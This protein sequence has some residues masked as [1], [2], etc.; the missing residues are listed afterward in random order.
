MLV[1]RLLLLLV[2]A[3][4]ATS[5]PAAY[6]ASPEAA[7]SEEAPP[8]PPV[9]NVMP[10]V[11]VGS[12][13]SELMLG[14]LLSVV[15][16]PITGCLGILVVPPFIHR[17]HGRHGAAVTSFVLRLG[18]PFVGAF[19]AMWLSPDCRARDG[20]SCLF[21]GLLGAGAGELS[22]MVIDYT[23][24]AAADDEPVPIFRA[25][26]S[27]HSVLAGVGVSHGG[28]TFSVAGAF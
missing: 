16:C 19:G 23:V 8:P 12:Y 15:A 28:L 6:A 25:A 24:L 13:A 17:S 3:L 5:A 10:P 7:D 21:Y 11:H 20:Q 1:R 26:S 2:L 27:G 4:V 22:A 18:M 9:V 14:D